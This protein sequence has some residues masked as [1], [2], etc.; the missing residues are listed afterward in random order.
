MYVCLYLDNQNHTLH[1]PAN[2]LI[3]WDAEGKKFLKKKCRRL[4]LFIVGHMK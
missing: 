3:F 1:R 2:F 4:G